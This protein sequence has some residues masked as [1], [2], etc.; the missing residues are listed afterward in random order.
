M[1]W[2]ALAWASKQ[3]T[4]SSNNKLVLIMLANYADDKNKCFPSF[5]KLGEM[6]ELS[7]ATIIRCI[8][9]L[10]ISGFVSREERYTEFDG[11]NRQTSN[12]YTLNVVGYHNDTH[13][14]HSDTPPSITVTPHITSHKEPLTYTEDFEGFW[15]VY[16]NNG[17][18]KKKAFESWIK[19]TKTAISVEE[20][21]S[22][23]EKYNKITTGKDVKFIPHCTTWLNQQR[24]ETVKEH[25]K[26]KINL[27]HLVG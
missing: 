7:R 15:K 17:G 1:S 23:C 16:P 12:Q 21:F 27:N 22:L 20:L 26:Q 9:S 24:W 6:T 19:V 25:K 13:Q 11:G 4:G 10:E 14:S 5:K 18:S 2:S 3:Q 8:R